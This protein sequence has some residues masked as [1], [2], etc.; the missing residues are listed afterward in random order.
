MAYGTLDC[1]EQCSAA[2]TRKIYDVP[3]IQ[4]ARPNKRT[5]GFTLLRPMSRVSG[6]GRRARKG[7]ERV[8]RRTAR[9]TRI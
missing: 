3:M 4:A 1:R 9:K 2:S 8:L 5:G 7:V 6:A